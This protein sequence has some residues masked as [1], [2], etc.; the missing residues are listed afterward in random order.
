MALACCC[1]G[2]GCFRRG[3][4]PVRAA[5][6]SE[7]PRG[8]ERGLLG[9]LREERVI[10]LCRP[11]GQLTS[12]RYKRLCT[13]WLSRELCAQSVHC[14]APKTGKVVAITNCFPVRYVAKTSPI[15]KELL[16]EKPYRRG[17]PAPSARPVSPRRARLNSA[18]QDGC[19]TA[20]SL[21]G[22]IR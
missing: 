1:R 6:Q 3:I 11:V 20:P 19:L 15:R 18:I 4:T 10:T 8:S 16:G 21:C 7:Q 12:T 2:C 14:F 17:P 5:I 13:Q 22:L 9:A